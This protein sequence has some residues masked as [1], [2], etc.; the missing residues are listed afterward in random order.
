[1]GSPKRERSE[2]Q[3]LSR[4]KEVLRETV[5]ARTSEKTQSSS[6]NNSVIQIDKNV[7]FNQSTRTK[8]KDR[9]IK[10]LTSNICGFKSKKGSLSNIAHTNNIDVICLSETHCERDTIP[11]LPGYITYYRNRVSKSKGGICMFFKKEYEDYL[12]K[13]ETGLDDNEYFVCKVSCFNPQ[14][15]LVLQY[16]V[17]EN[18][19]SNAEILGIQS[20]VFNIIKSYNEEEFDILWTG[21]LNL[22]LGDGERLKGNNPTQS[23]GGKNLLKFV[24][25]ESLHICNW[26]DKN[27]TH[28][29]RSGG[30][31]NILDLC[32]TNVPDKVKSFSVDTNLSH[33]PYRVRKV[34]GGLQRK[35]TDHLSLLTTLNVKGKVM[36]NNKLKSWNYYKKGGDERFHDEMEIMSSAFLD[37]VMNR[38]LTIDQ[39]HSRLLKRINNIKFKAYGKTSVTQKKAQEMSDH[40]IWKKRMKEVEQSI[41]SLKKFKITDRIWETRNNIS[42]KFKDKQFVSVTDPRTGKLTSSKEETY[43]AILDYNYQLLRKD[44]TVKENEVLE[45]ERVKEM[46]TNSAMECDTLLGDDEFTWD[47]MIKVVEKIKL[48]NKNVYRDLTKSGWLFKNA[49]LSFFNRCYRDEQIPKVWEETVLMKLYKNKGKRTDL[50]MNRFIH[51]KSFLPKTFEKLVMNKIGGRLD[52]RTPEFQIGG[53]KKSSTT[54]HLLT[55][56][57]YM[58]RLEKE[59]GGGIC[60]FMD[61]KTCFDK[62]TLSDSLYECAQA[63]VVGKPLRTVKAITNNLTI[64]IQG[65]PNTSR[66]KELSNC[67]GQGT[68][69]APTGT[70]VTMASTLETNMAKKEAEKVFNDEN[71]TLTPISGPICLEPLLFVDD[72]NKTCMKAEE[73]SVMGT[74]ITETLDE[75]KME[76][77]PE[78]SGLLVF[79]RNRNKLKEDVLTTP[80]VIQGFTMG[81]KDTETYLGMQFSTLGSNDSIMKTLEA[82]RLKCNIKAMEIRRKLDDD[83]VQ[84]IGWLATAKTVFNAVIVSTLTYGCGAWVNMLKKHSE[85]IE[86]TQRQCLFTVLDISNRSNYRNIL[87]TCKI[88]PALDVIKKMKICFVNQMIH[89]KK[90]GI[91]YDTL[92]AEHNKGELKTL[93]D[94]ASEYCGYFNIRDV[95]EIFI[96]QEKLKAQIYKE[97][98]NK[99]WLSLLTSKKAP[100]APRR[101]GEKDRFYHTLPR[102][103]AKCA[104]LHKAGELNFRAN[105]RNESMKRYGTIECVVPGC[106]QPDTL[107]HAMECYGYVTKF[108]EGGSPH[109]WVEFLSELDLERFKK[110]KTSLTR[111]NN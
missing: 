83:R 71:F 14:L 44:E 36:D 66:C 11:E 7:N 69:Y 37:D 43:D 64:K 19:Y 21:D 98:M 60:Q 40:D 108:K 55:L 29:D 18:R 97:S 58:K 13:L 62:M 12:M 82:R 47:E 94:E 73:S 104:L 84:G 31:S 92:T 90:Q 35:Y 91:C 16:G 102:H 32:I 1:M 8:I 48:D 65:D 79:G 54:E 67:L 25:E 110:Y 61:I 63:G 96:P 23:F 17:I 103:Q 4:K 76:A 105:R 45:K 78:K 2:I 70:G 26:D 111:F 100:E 42:Y 3:G 99:L 53:R 50:K 51:L 109:E 85:H 77:H 41:H 106:G 24:E 68:V 39:V 81:F 89:M 30:T 27:H 80:T 59:Q 57:M 22:H 9:S 49:L 88:M 86:Q 72:M 20:E 15:V 75:L 34:K 107:Q 95:S 38:E 93:I 10:I 101:D 74:A 52:S 56:M 33:T 5:A 6:E 46:V 87:S 28:W